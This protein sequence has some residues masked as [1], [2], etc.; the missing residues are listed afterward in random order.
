MSTT[1][2]TIPVDDKAYVNVSN[3]NLNC[4]LFLDSSDALR[5]AI[6]DVAPAANAVD[7]VLARGPMSGVPGAASAIGFENLGAEADVW[8]R[9]E[10]GATIVNA[11]RGD[12]IIRFYR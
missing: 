5:L 7:Y 9:A 4:T 11:M 8:V 1:T 2:H 3:G 10:K 12:T 6:N